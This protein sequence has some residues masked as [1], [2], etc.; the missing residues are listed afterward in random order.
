MVSIKNTG[1]E[2]PAAGMSEA[3][4][5]LLASSD[6][7]RLAPLAAGFWNLAE[8][9]LFRAKSI[10]EV[11]RLLSDNAIE[12][13][14]IDETL[15]DISGFALAE[16]VAKNHPFVNS[17]LVSELPDSDFHELTEGLGVLMRLRSPL[18]EGQAGGV[19]DRLAHI[20]RDRSLAAET[21]RVE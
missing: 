11:S 8:A 14:V 13:V 15:A 6:M 3:L 9:E 10:S 21:G 7:G 2:I 18:E 12:L 20:R 4:K 16:Q 1:A 5:I 17:I 19:L